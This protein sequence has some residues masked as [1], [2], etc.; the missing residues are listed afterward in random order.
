MRLGDIS[1]AA[2]GDRTLFL[3]IAP[4]EAVLEIFRAHACALH[5]S[6][7]QV[8]GVGELSITLDVED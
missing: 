6:R 7:A 3:G 4:R 2:G 1:S 5:Q 8:L